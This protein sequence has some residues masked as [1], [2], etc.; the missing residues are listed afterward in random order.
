[1]TRSAL[2]APLTPRPGPNYIYRNEKWVCIKDIKGYESVN[3]RTVVEVNSF[4]H[5]EM[6]EYLIKQRESF[7]LPIPGGLPTAAVGFIESK[8]FDKLCQYLTKAG[9][10]FTSCITVLYDAKTTS[11]FE[12][13]NAVY[14][15]YTTNYPQVGGFVVTTVSTD[16]AGD[17]PTTHYFVEIYDAE[18][19]PISKFTF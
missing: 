6:C 16:G 4:N 14:E 5:K 15:D 12:L 2:L 13:Y 3:F 11:V 19:L 18:G 10:V 8:L 17:L 7:K 1:M 9:N